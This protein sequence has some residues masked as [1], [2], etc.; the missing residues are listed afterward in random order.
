M[1]YPSTWVY[2]RGAR[3]G[4][5]YPLNRRYAVI[6]PSAHHARD[7]SSILAGTSQHPC[8]H[9]AASS[10]A[11][12]QQNGVATTHG[13]VHQGERWG[14]A[15]ERFE[16]AWTDKYQTEIT[17]TGLGRAGPHVR[18]GETIGPWLAPGPNSTGP[19][20]VAHGARR[21]ARGQRRKGIA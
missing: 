5:Q 4:L 15:H 11:V 1:Q 6:R 13:I 19:Q 14:V 9:L 3:V 7:S 21:M 16:R 18:D 20:F 2:V 17:T 10:Q 8:S 12:R